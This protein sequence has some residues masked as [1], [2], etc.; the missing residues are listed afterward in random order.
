[1]ADYW[2]SNDRK[3]C[4]FCKCWIADNKASV[5]FHE[6]GKRHQLNIQK[7]ITD[8]SRNSYKAQQEQNKI[9]ADLK[10]MN[11]AAMKAYMQD[12]SAC[13]DISSRELY[14]KQQQEEAK[15]AAA[16]AVGSAGP[17]AE[18]AEPTGSRP[19]APPKRGREAD[20]FYLAGGDS[21]E[22]TKSYREKAAAKRKHSE[23]ASKADENRSMWVEAATDE[24]YTYYWNVKSGESAWECPPE[25]FMKKAEYEK[26]SKMAWQKQKET[27]E[28]DAKY[29]LE[30]ADEIAARLRRENMAQIFRQNRKAKE[31]FE[32]MAD[33][34]REAEADAKLDR[35]RNP[36]GTWEKVEPRDEKPVD[37]QLPV[38]PAPLYVPS[39]APEAP[40]PKF[41]E[42]VVDHVP[43]EVTAT[44]SDAFVKKRKFQRNVRQR[45]D[46]D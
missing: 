36:Y 13:A 4:D 35:A 17:V 21:D 46:V 38:V 2:K 28:S 32:K 6:N 1:M 15:E 37:L 18:S 33:R 34:K 42:K 20:P 10:K 45:L 14:E 26:L 19:K 40:Q 39:V 8:I 27:A 24:G 41:K 16:L 23:D 43:A 9:D 31:D 11:D 30:N 7:R 12:I 5:Q 3:F 22:D 29:E 25:G 44:V